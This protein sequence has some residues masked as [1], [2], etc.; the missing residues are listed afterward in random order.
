MLIGSHEVEKPS[1]IVKVVESVVE[2]NS[3]GLVILTVKVEE[4]VVTP[5]NVR[6]SSF[7]GLAVVIVPKFIVPEE[8]GLTELVGETAH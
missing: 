2:D 3:D 1:V 7:N 4:P 5:V 8:G 6:V